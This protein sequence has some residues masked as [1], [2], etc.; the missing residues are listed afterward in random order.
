[1][2]LKNIEMIT[3]NIFLLKNLC[4][5][6]INNA[7]ANENNSN[8]SGIRTDIDTDVMLANHINKFKIIDNNNQKLNSNL[9]EI[10]NNY[11]DE[12]KELKLEYDYG[13]NVIDGFSLEVG[14]N[15]ISEKKIVMIKENLHAPKLLKDILKK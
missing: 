7:N 6:Y 5:R 13:I 2:I 3:K 9:D 12:Q 10:I 15:G 11:K 8:D 14:R 1:M 4:N